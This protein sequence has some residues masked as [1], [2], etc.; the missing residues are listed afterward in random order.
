MPVSGWIQMRIEGSRS[1]GSGFS[2]PI[3]LIF[4]TPVDSME[5][6]SPRLVS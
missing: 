2:A 4:Q 3:V 6:R 5:L 1:Q